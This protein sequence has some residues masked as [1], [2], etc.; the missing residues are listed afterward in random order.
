MRS[1][2]HGRLYSLESLGVK[3]TCP[4]I[5]KMEVVDSWKPERCCESSTRFHGGGF[6][7][8]TETFVLSWSLGILL[9]GNVY[10]FR[11]NALV[12]KSLQLPFSYPWTRLFNTQRWFVS[13]NRISAETCL[14]IRFLGTA[15]MSQYN[16]TI[17]EALTTRGTKLFFFFGISSKFTIK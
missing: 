6:F 16:R 17:L 14:P 12:S 2:L 9:R 11:S 13:K 8:Y 5:R 1:S 7:V 3:Q 4:W 15:Y 10:Y